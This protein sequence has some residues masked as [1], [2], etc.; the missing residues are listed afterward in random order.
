[1]KAFNNFTQ[2]N[3]ITRNRKKHARFG[4]RIPTKILCSLLILIASILFSS[5]RWYLRTYGA[6]GFDSILFTLFSNLKGV[7]SAI[8]TDFIYGA[9]VPAVIFTIIYTVLF[10]IPFNNWRYSYV[11]KRYEIVITFVLAIILTIIAGNESNFFNYMHKISHQTL[12]YEE[13]YVDPH[14]VNIEFPEKKRNLIYIFLESMETSYL[15]KREGG[16]LPKD[17]MPE[18]Y[19]LAKENINFSHN[20]GVGG[21]LTPSGTTWTVSAMS[22]QTSAI[23]LKAS[24]GALD[25]NEYGKESFLPGAVT[26]NNILSENGYNQALIVG[27]DASFANRDVYFKDHEIGNIYDLNTARAEG[28]IPEDYFVWWG[29]ED[30]LL[31]EYSKTKIKEMAKADEPFSIVMLTVDTHFPEGYVC[32][33][34]PDTYNE[35]YNNVISCASNQLNEFIKWLKK[36]DFYKDT[37]VVISG[38][39][40]TMD[41]DY[42]WRNF[43]EEYERHIYN[44]FINSAA[45]SDTYKNRTFTSFDMFPTT[46]A[47]MG[48]KIEG[49]RL[50]LGTNL[51]SDQK[52]RA[53]EMGFEEFDEQLS[54]SSNYYI[55]QFMVKE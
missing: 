33:L 21:F 19:K 3:F 42:A 47:A 13:K 46:L 25:N 20:S 34:C 10:F 49:D 51:F 39:H 40:L 31:Y 22:S 16:A 4:A 6:T 45:E 35:Q 50:G 7:D 38:D 52:T 29:M 27:S 24:P 2:K 15:A 55:K 43:P 12:I 18:L 36:Q 54:M 23:P 32:D 44:C 48:C 9:L 28:F 53:E 8:V 1:M 30:K 37:T 5:T 26:I 41:Y 17:V 11:K 14:S